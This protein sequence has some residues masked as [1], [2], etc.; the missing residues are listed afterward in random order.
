MYKPKR[1]I[2]KLLT[3]TLAAGLLPA[4]PAHAAVPDHIEINQI[5]GGGG[6]GDTPFS[7]SFIELYN[8]TDSEIVLSDYKITYSSNR[9]NS[10]GKHAGS[11]WQSDGTIAVNE[12]TLEGSIPANHS[13]LIRCAA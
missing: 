7:N 11:T 6:K 13:Y 2:A 9:E 4:F 5:Y 10:K 12:L 8:P 1:F 3:L